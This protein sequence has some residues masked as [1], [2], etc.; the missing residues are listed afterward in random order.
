MAD[1]I[2]SKKK[3]T[4][5]EISKFTNIVQMLFRNCPKLAIEKYDF[6]PNF[7]DFAG[8]SAIQTL[9]YELLKAK[10]GETFV[11]SYL[12]DILFPQQIVD[13]I[14][15]VCHTREIE[16]FHIA[17]LFKLVTLF[18]GY[19]SMKSI[20]QTSDNIDSLYVSS[21]EGQESI[22]LDSL[23]D[24]VLHLYD[25]E[26][27]D[28]FV[29]LLPLAKTI[30]SSISDKFLS[31]HAS[32]FEFLAKMTE[33]E[34]AIQ[35]YDNIATDIMNIFSKFPEH[36]IAL[37]SVVEL[38]IKLSDID[39]VGVKEIEK[40]LSF[41]VDIFMKDEKVILRAWTYNF[42]KSI[43]DKQNKASLLIE[44]L[45]EDVISKLKEI[46]NEMEKSYGG[47]VPKIEP[48][49]TSPDQIFYLLRV[50]MRG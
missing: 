41:I 30:I 48:L 38:A 1:D 9:F 16:D 4:P 22:V 12:K 24:S 10:D 44:K 15:V 49:D 28:L 27:V 34:G 23:W 19:P 37:S 33:C 21:Q 32:C 8:Y 14:K 45:P 20:F 46:D 13:R 47:P 39:D 2:F 11:Y 7:L 43:R 29:P 42:L 17:G 3:L 25:S 36:T 50:F 6:L 40:M 26:S 31:Y 5:L 35:F 18:A